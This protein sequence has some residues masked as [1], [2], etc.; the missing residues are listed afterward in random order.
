MRYAERVESALRW[1]EQRVG[2]IKYDGKAL[3]PDKLRAQI[4]SYHAFQQIIA[5]RQLDF[6]GT[7]AHGDL[8]SWFVTC[9]RS[10]VYVLIADLL[11]ALTFGWC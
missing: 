9:A 2:E 5:D 11:V 8:T 1:L 4:R 10:F 3:T 7:K 6:V